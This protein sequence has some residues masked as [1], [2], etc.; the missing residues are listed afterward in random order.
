MS[1]AGAVRRGATKAAYQLADDIKD[2]AAA[3]IAKAKD[4]L[5]A[6]GRTAVDVGASLTEMGLDKA[7][8]ALLIGGLGPNYKSDKALGKLADTLKLAPLAARSYGNNSR[9]ARKDGANSKNSALYGLSTAVTDAYIE[10]ILDGLAGAYGVGRLEEVYAELGL[11]DVMEDGEKLRSIY[12][13][14]CTHV[15][16]D[17]V[18]RKNAY[19]HEKS[20]AYAALIKGTAT[21]QG[22][23]VLLYRM[24]RE[25]G[26]DCRVVTGTGADES[27]EQL[28]AWNIAALD[29]RY[30]NLDATWDAGAEEYCWILRGSAHFTNHAAGEAF[31]SGS[32]LKRYPMAAEDYTRDE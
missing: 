8:S 3:S 29:G 31:T 25:N 9:I 20:T 6:A 15:S 14:V 26:V 23:A 28:H 10:D 11:N 27:G 16:Y 32:F 30:Y 24:L 18:H 2:S 19:H 5:D 12:D 1:M 13:Y 21:C 7:K 4:G 22:Y 17:K